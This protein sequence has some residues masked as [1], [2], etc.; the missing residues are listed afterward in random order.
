MHAGPEIGVASTKA[1]VTM[2][3]ALALVGLWL[4]PAR[5]ALPARDVAASVAALVELPSLVEKTLEV[6]AAM[7][8]L[9]REVAGARDVLYLGRGLQH[10]IA[11]EGAL[12]L[13]EISYLHAEGY[14][15]GEM[16]H[17]PIA[18][19]AE[20]LPVVALAP[21]D[22]S[23][24]RMVGNIE[25]VRARGGRVIAVTN[26]GDHSVA[27]IADVVVEVPATAPALAPVLT[28][29]PLQLL[30]Y[31]VAVGLGRDV[32]RPRNLAKSV[33]VE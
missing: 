22:A 6:D 15:G 23:Y 7:A 10:A 27:T 2:L 32:D 13:K 18:L 33:T 12:K 4:G 14:A 1:F 16:K 31:H 11:L 19:V 5:G 24:D 28:V 21:R 17:G 26:P 3:V 30:A 20:G 29:I 9:A 25:E 8:A